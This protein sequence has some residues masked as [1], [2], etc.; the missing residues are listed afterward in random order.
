MTT[1]PCWAR[2]DGPLAPYAEG[3]RVDLER[4][5]YTPLT[6]AGHIRLVAHLSRW[7][8]EQHLRPS[9]LTQ[10]TV[11]AYCAE[12]RALGYVNSVTGRSL[13]P[14]LD[15]L[16][17]LGVTP[18]AAPAAPTTPVEVLLDRYRDYLSVERGLA[19]TT[20][21]LNVRLVRP[22]LLG[23]AETEG[24]LDLGG[25]DAGEVTA[26]VLEQS[27]TRPASVGRI[28]TALRSLLSFLHIGGLIEKPLSTAVLA[29]PGWTQTGLPKALPAEQVT[30]LLTSCDRGTATGRRDFAILTL[31]IRLGLRAGEVAAL[32]LSDIHWRHGEITVRGKGNRCDR[33]PLPADVGEAIVDYLRDGRPERA[34][35]DTVFVRAQAPYRA[36]T[37]TG[38]TTVVVIAGRRAGLGL[39]G[40]HR[41][42][43]S[44]ATAMLSAGGS[45]AEIGQV[46]RHQRLL[47]T[48]IYAKVDH[49]SLRQLA[50]PWPGGAA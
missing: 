41:L 20:V 10:A 6:A 21:E 42:R 27:R 34:Q 28:V 25:L 14:L 18:T 30:A 17:S 29:V 12:R 47:T 32:A 45:L 1:V 49:R 22:F 35:D 13:R 33:L 43:H 7:M 16:R 50:R 40:A 26:F 9:E 15:Y 5:G 46:L 39:I 24:R 4:L 36:L 8:R 11:D 2:V 48:A 19:T 44:A 38:V 31:L 23:L 3:L 37:S